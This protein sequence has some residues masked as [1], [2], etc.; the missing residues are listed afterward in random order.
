MAAIR[1]QNGRVLIKDGRVSC[2]CC[3]G[4]FRCEI[5]DLFVDNTVAILPLTAGQISSFLVGGDLRVQLQA[6]GESSFT[7][8]VSNPSGQAG[9]V[10]SVSHSSSI[11]HDKIL[12]VPAFTQ[13]VFV[14]GNNV[15]R[16]YAQVTDFEGNDSLAASYG[17]TIDGSSSVT[18]PQGASV[19][20]LVQTRQQFDW[21]M[22]VAIAVG[23]YN[24]EPSLRLGAEFRVIT[25]TQ[26][27]Y[28]GDFNNSSGVFYNAST[29]PQGF[30]EPWVFASSVEMEGLF[31]NVSFPMYIRTEGGIEPT[32]NLF[33]LTYTPSAP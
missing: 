6:E 14:L 4:G 19:G 27:I 2:E 3:E 1:T 12:S 11:A 5:D 22:T 16:C 10:S 8:T 20:Q 33:S 18:C 21:Q 13:A 32:I 25:N 26:G 28:S 23:Y 31:N 7:Y 30:A 24:D 9:C 17:V 29:G 15:G